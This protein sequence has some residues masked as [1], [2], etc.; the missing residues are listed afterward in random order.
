MLSMCARAQPS[1]KEKPTAEGLSTTPRTNKSAEQPTT[2]VFS[3]GLLRVTAKLV[4]VEETKRF[5]LAQEQETKTQD[6]HL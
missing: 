6:K 4:K 5:K 3:R 1:K 2:F